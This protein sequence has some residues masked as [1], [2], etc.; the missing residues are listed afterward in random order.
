MKRHDHQ[1][2]RSLYEQW[3]ASGESKTVFATRNGV[4]PTTFYYWVQKFKKSF[5]AAS[6]SVPG[7]GFRPIT[8]EGAAIVN[9]GQAM[10][11]IHYP[12][13]A[14]LELYSPVEA[15]FLKTLVE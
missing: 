6:P 2:M 12:S 13:G 15:Q 5:L 1:Q 4:R 11:V 10:A 9:Q 8:I 3:Q 7:S 14:R